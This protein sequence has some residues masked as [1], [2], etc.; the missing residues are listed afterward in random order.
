MSPSNFMN[1]L[2]DDFLDKLEESV[3]LFGKSILEIGCGK[4]S[5][6]VQIAKRCAWL[7][8]LDPSA[9]L[10]AFAKENNASQ[11]INYSVGM[12]QK[13]GFQ[14]QKFDV[15]IFTLSLHHV[16]VEEMVTAIDEAVRV[17]K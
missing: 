11:N 13:L 9:D 7:E 2:K 16:R 5:R 1:R 3:P 10:V 4:G 17:T 6:S 8:A 12:A 15:S 14:D